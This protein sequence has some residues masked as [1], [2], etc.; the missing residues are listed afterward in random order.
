MKQASTTIRDAL[1]GGL[2]RF[3]NNPRDI[4]GLVE[5]H[6]LAP[7]EQGPELHETITDLNASG[8]SWGGVGRFAI[9]YIDEDVIT[10]DEV[11]F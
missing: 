9:D 5:C 4:P 3:A 8:I 1:K 2:R 10:T 7:A 6:N 11:T